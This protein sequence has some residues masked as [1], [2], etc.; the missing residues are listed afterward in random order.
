MTSFHIV[1]KPHKCKYFDIS[2]LASYQLSS[3]TNK[4]TLEKN[5]ISASIVVNS[6]VV[7]QL[8]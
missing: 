2:A 4:F 8:A 3:Y 5:L 1:V 7:Y 6:L